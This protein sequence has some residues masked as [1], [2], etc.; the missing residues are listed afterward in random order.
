[1]ELIASSHSIDEVRRYITAGSLAYLSVDGML[2]TVPK[3]SVGA[4]C[5][6]PLPSDNYCIACFSGRY[7]IPFKREEISQPGLFEGV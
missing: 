2:K 4:H 1:R 7:P 5:N 3:P 6:V